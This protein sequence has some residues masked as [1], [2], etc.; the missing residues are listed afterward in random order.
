MNMERKIGE[1]FNYKG[2]MLEVLKCESCRNCYFSQTCKT[3]EIVLSL[4]TIRRDCNFSIYRG[5][6][7]RCKK[8]EQDIGIVGHCEPFWRNDSTAIN[9]KKVKESWKDRLVRYLASK[10][11]SLRL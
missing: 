2:I 11:R 1:M 10:E 4:G 3:M 6:Y 8:D 7:K 5:N 9:Y